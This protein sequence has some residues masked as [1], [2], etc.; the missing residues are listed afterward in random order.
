MGKMKEIYTMYTEGVPIS[1]IAIHFK[2]DE[3][4]INNLIYNYYFDGE[5]E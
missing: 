5:E 3:I 4:I 1:K 2:V